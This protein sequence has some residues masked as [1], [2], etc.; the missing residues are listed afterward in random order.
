[1]VG[2]ESGQVWRHKE[3]ALYQVVMVFDGPFGPGVAYVDKDGFGGVYMRDLLQF[4][5]NFKLE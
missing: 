4:V 1:M 3:G 5:K 2:P